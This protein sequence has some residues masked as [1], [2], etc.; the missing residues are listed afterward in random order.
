MLD[1]AIKVLAQRGY[2]ALRIEEVAELAG[3][4]KTT[5]YRRWPTKPPLVAAAIRSAAGQEEALPD[6]GDVEKDLYLLVR[7]SARFISTP[8][9]RAIGTIIPAERGD[10]EVE[11][12]TRSLRASGTARRM[13]VLNRAIRRGELPSDAPVSLMLEAIFSPLMQRKIRFEEPLSDQSL[14]VLVR[15]V[16][17]GAK[18][19]MKI[20]RVEPKM[21]GKSAGSSGASR[22]RLPT[23]AL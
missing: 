3:V 2:A 8:T 4:S 10:P 21:A 15:L 1:A 6:T 11:E 9:G 13:E 14:R 22:R 20:P 5:I 17:N 16:V 19:G 12:L 18:A 23:R 7:R